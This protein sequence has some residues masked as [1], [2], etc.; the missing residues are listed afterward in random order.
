[1]RH[2]L[3]PVVKRSGRVSLNGI[4]TRIDPRG[5]ELGSLLMNKLTGKVHP[6]KF[7]IEA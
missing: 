3:N 6:D 7:K 2:L 1:M 5:I 4:N